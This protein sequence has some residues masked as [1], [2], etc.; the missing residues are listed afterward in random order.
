MGRREARVQATQGSLYCAHGAESHRSVH[1]D[2][3][4]SLRVKKTDAELR[5]GATMLAERK[6][7]IYDICVKYGKSW[8]TTTYDRG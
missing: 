6:K 1:S 5:T 4:D 3:R 2:W 8:M 7:I